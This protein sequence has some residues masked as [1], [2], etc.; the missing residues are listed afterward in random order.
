MP[1]PAFLVE[2][3][4]EQRIIQRLCPNRPVRLIGCNGDEVSMAAI[5]KALNAR[6]RLLGDCHPVIIILDRER[7]EKCCEELIQE[8]SHLLDEYEHRG[9]YVIGMADRTIENWILSDWS[10][11][12]QDDPTYQAMA[13]DSQGK[14][15]KT[16]I[17]HLMPEQKFYHETTIGVELFLKCR[18]LQLY[19][20]NES[21]RSFVCQLDLECWWLD[22]IDQRFCPASWSQPQA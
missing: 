10:N 4:M 11:I 8:L 3:Q 22:G 21:F 20:A 19:A 2:G 16:I 14:H 6:L 15:G 5:A 12:L 17:K 13:D 18:A 9:R 1:K 7:R